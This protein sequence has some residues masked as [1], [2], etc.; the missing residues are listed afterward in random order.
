MSPKPAHEL[1]ESIRKRYKRASRVEK[2][3]ILN[4]FCANHSCHRKSA[5]RKIKQKPYQKLKISYKKKGRPYIYHDKKLIKVLECIWSTAYFPC[6]THLKACIPIWLPHYE[7]SFKPVPDD[8]KKLILKISAATINRLLYSARIKYKKRGRSTTKPGTLLKNQI[9]IKTE[10]WNEFRPGFME[11]DT[12]AH[13]G[14]STAGQYVNTV[15]AVDIAS[16]WTE[17]RAVWG[18]GEAASAEQVKDI[19]KSVPFAILGFDADSG[20]EFLNYH[21]YRYFVNRKVPVQFTRSRAYKKNDNAHVE[22]KNWTHVRQWL[23]YVRF[24]NPELVPLLNDLYKNE[25]RLFHNFFC[26]SVKLLEKKRIGSKTVKKHDKPK[27]PYQRL[28]ESEYVSSNIKERLTKTF[29]SLNP[30]VLRKAIMVKIK[31]IRKLI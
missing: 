12:V 29:E 8:I 11:F 19:E 7:N 10:Q 4:E 20:G 1:L 9:P 28:I 21:L 3:V 13:C 25:W 2:T 26:P 30:F 17:Q 16:G 18:K 27:T 15:D 23:G 5:I 24:E 6:A 14:D 22:Q 31:E